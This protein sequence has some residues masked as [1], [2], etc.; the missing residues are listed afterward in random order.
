[1][2]SIKEQ[3]DT[4]NSSCE[5]ASEVRAYL[6]AN[7]VSQKQASVILGVSPSAVAIYLGGRPFSEKTAEKWS[8]AFGFCKDFLVNGA[9]TIVPGA[10]TENRYPRTEQ[11]TA[12]QNV[13]IATGYNFM[14]KE[15]PDENEVPLAAVMRKTYRQQ[16]DYLGN[17][18]CRHTDGVVDSSIKV[19]DIYKWQDDALRS[20]REQMQKK[21]ERLLSIESIIGKVIGLGADT[22]SALPTNAISTLLLNAAGK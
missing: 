13:L 7:R 2:Q 15:K 21:E 11:L 1:M 20:M 3:Q 5:I 9:G 17:S 19:G 12:A 16:F 14:N 18:F 10:T 6:E 22:V 8:E 4:L